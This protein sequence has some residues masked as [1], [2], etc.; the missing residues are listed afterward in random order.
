MIKATGT[1]RT[2]KPIMVSHHPADCTKVPL[3]RAFDR[4]LQSRKG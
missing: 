2:I 4:G 3:F 1:T